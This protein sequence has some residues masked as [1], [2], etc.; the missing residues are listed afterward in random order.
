MI[1]V[2]DNDSAITL[3]EHMGHDQV[4]NFLKDYGFNDSSFLS[5][6]KTTPNDSATFFEKLYKGQIVNREFSQKMLDVLFRQRLNDRLPKYLPLGTHVAHK[7]G[8]LDT[9]KHDAGIVQYQG[10]DDYLI[11]V[12]T[13]TPDPEN[14]AEIT[15]QIS[16]DVFDYFKN[17]K[18]SI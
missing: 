2:S 4:E 17:K 6:P 15:A 16:K 3:Y 14:A 18:Q 13:D 1:T 7:T 11:V 8:E 12:M 10:N 9:F 5:P